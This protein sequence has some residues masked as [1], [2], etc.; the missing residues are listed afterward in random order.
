MF[1]EKFEDNLS[2]V[3][4]SEDV[5][6]DNVWAEK[7]L[8]N[9]SVLADNDT[10]TAEYNLTNYNNYFAF[11]NR[12]NLILGGISITVLA[13]LT[14]LTAIVIFNRLNSSTSIKSISLSE[15]ELNELYTRI[16][17]ANPTFS[18]DNVK[19]AGASE[20]LNATAMSSSYLDAK[21]IAPYYGEENVVYTNVY[22]TT[23]GPQI[24]SCSAMNYGEYVD[25]Y[26]E[27]SEST[28]LQTGG[29]V[30]SVSSTKDGNGNVTSYYL[31]I[32]NENENTSINYMG[33]RYA[34]KMIY[35]NSPRQEILMLDSQTS[36][37]GVAVTDTTMIAPDVMPD[38]EVP[39]LSEDPVIRIQQL[40]GE[41]A[42]IVG[43][44]NENGQEYYVV[45]SNYDTN[46]DVSLYKDLAISSRSFNEVSDV[47]NKII[48]QYKI[49]PVDFKVAA[50]SSYLDS[51]TEDRLISRV[52]TSETSRSVN[53][54]ADVADVFTFPF[55]VEV[56]EIIVPSYSAE[57][58]VNKTRDFINSNNV[59]VLNATGL[60]LTASS[61]Y[62]YNNDPA[63]D[64][65]GYYM[66]RGFYA[67]GALGDKAYQA[68]TMYANSYDPNTYYEDGSYYPATVGSI[69]Y[70]NPDYSESVNF[71]IYK[72]EARNYDNLFAVVKSGK[73]EVSETNVNIN[74][75]G[76]SIPATYFAY[77]YSDAFSTAPSEGGFAEGSD[78]MSVDPVLPMEATTSYELVFK[79]NGF[80]YQVAGYSVN[81]T[82]LSTLSYRSL[83]A[84]EL[85]TIYSTMLTANQND[86]I[87]Y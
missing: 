48:Q 14:L 5:K 21:L 63:E 12:K 38:F 40:F 61:I 26:R 81:S 37:G 23:Y 71:S 36:E 83:S 59:P 56:R 84:A 45:E 69:Y 19:N 47:T 39:P 72:D 53:G 58:E 67:D 76:T 65:Y 29:Y 17:D 9:L 6:P 30:N 1:K 8:H 50:T 54:I 27:I 31:S 42:V 41:N 22:D 78:G 79:Y 68:A 51:A 77:T 43:T 35:E 52:I 2:N 85:E 3:F 4:K 75:D 82:N 18:A 73:K 86:V 64:P 25:G 57:D 10:N 20:A 24:G 60:N 55:N 44:I 87:L 11:M 46:C 70:N 80:I 34:V 32:S 7:T 74:V 66:D 49:S 13:V 15:S 33:G 16:A 28:N 62:V